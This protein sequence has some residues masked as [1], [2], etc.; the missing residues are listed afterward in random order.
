MTGANAAREGFGRLQIAGLI[1]IRGQRLASADIREKIEDRGDI[2][3]Q[4]KPSLDLEMPKPVASGAV[5]LRPCSTDV[6]LAG[7]DGHLI[8]RS[9]VQQLAQRYPGGAREEAPQCDVEPR[10]HLAKRAELTTLQRPQPCR[11]AQML[12]EITRRGSGKPQDQI[13]QIGLEQVHPVLWPRGGPIGEVLAP[14]ETTV[15]VLD[16]PEHRRTVSHHAEGSGHGRLDRTPHSWGLYPRDLNR[17]FQVLKSSPD[18]GA[19]PGGPIVIYSPKR[20]ENS[21]HRERL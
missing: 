18:Q 4:I 1:G 16:P 7:T 5:D 14:A 20:S 15:A 19:N 6:R 2:G 13:A 9:P 17:A 11:T 8:S 12:K 10:D 3:R 21:G